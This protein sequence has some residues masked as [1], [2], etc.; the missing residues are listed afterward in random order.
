MA[1]STLKVLKNEAEVVGRV[2]SVDLELG[3]SRQGKENI[4]GRVVVLV[5][6]NVDGE[7][8]SHDIA[9]RVYSNKFNRKGEVSGLYKGYETV[10]NEYKSIADTGNKKEADLVHVQGSL[11]LNEFIGQDG[12]KRS[13][14]NVVAKFFNRLDSKDDVKRLK[15]PKAKVV[16][17]GVIENIKDVVGEDGLPTD[18]KKLQFFNVDF[19]GELNENSQPIIPVEV[20]VPS[21]IADKFD[22]LYDVG[23]TGKFTLKINNYAEDADESEV[24]EEIDGFGDTEDL[25]EVKKNFVN[26]LEVVGGSL[27]Y[28][29]GREYDEEQIKEAKQWRAKAISKL[30]EGY[31]PNDTPNAFGEGSKTDEKKTESKPKETEEDLSPDELDDLDF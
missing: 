10:M 11:D 17:E 3:K 20:I 13:N 24:A 23:D 1:E 19:F 4:K 5:E 9:I 6:E 8:R 2:K 29:N 25:A 26:N 28:D 16:I 12:Q 22:E 27:P 7:L 30:E 15:G 31:V 14:N 18:D 21:D